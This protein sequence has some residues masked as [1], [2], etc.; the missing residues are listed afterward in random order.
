MP[1][2]YTGDGSYMVSVTV[3]NSLGG[4]AQQTTTVDVFDAAPT[5]NLAMGG[6][7]VDASGNLSVGYTSSPA[8]L[9]RRLRSA[10]IVPWTAFS[11]A[12]WCSPWTLAI[13]RSWRSARTR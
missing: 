4:S 6:F 11:W 12:T 5:T 8:R 3:A 10:F 2:T 13:P 7:T 1:H 9:P